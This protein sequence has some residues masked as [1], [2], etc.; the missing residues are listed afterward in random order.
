M[1]F[2]HLAIFAPLTHRKTTRGYK[3]DAAATSEAMLEPEWYKTGDVGYLDSSGYLIIVD[4]L[5]D[6]I[7]YKG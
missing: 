3:D 1:V 6:V 4:R 7:K 2:Y 5:K